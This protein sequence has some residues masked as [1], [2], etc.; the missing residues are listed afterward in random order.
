M[1]TKIGEVSEL[2]IESDQVSAFYKKHW[3]REIALSIP[4]FYQWQFTGSPI[5]NGIDHCMVA[6]N[7]DSSEL[8]GVMGLNRR[9]FLLNGSK[10]KGA[11]LTTWIV[12]NAHLGKGIGAKI[13]KEIQNRYDVLIGMG[14]SDMA[15]PIYMRSGFRYI[16]AIPRYVKVFDFSKIEGYAAF[17]PLGKKLAQQW[18]NVVPQ[19]FKAEALNSEKAELIEGIMKERFNFF[20]R[21]YSH[22]HWRYTKHPIFQYI[23]NIVYATDNDKGKGCIVCMRIENNIPGLNILHILD[24]F[25][26]PHDMQAAISFIN[27]FCIK[28]NIHLADFYCTSTGISSYFISSGWFSTNDDLCFQFPHL[29]HPIE[30]RKP[31]TT[32][33]TYWSR[34]DFTQMADIGKLYITKEDAD[35]D[36]PTVQTYQNLST[37][38]IQD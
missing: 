14:I 25:G 30:L 2:G 8:L 34:E 17:S 11:E 6:I 36:R 26:D 7:Q 28:N 4:S 18:S 10:L 21:D 12:D 33:L 38:Y 16:K 27:E 29:F 3:K 22:L 5:D 13:L 24:F 37:N 20:T 35:L 1:S 32:S 9:P 31:P 15:I 23:Q 19:E